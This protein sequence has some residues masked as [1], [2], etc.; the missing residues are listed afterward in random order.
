M[1]ITASLRHCASYKV[2]RFK[3]R[4]NADYDSMARQIGMPSSDLYNIEHNP[5]GKNGVA[6]PSDGRIK[7][8]LEWGWR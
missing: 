6:A 5:N 1:N 8:I 7:Q 2:R 4:N 3:L